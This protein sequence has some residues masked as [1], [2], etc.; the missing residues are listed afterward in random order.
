VSWVVDTSAL[1]AVINRERGAEIVDP[2]LFGAAISTVNLSEA[3]AKLTERG[4][5]LDEVR[6]TLGMTGLIRHAFDERA[7]YEAG[8]LRP[9]TRASGL[10]FAD[11]AC[12]ALARLT[13][14]PVLTADRR[15]ATIDLG[16]EVRVFR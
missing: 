2:L 1:L 9:L 15:W 12:L 10:S 4:L 5:P 16:I 7:A 8:M 14:L 3:V 13:T 11:R 6:D